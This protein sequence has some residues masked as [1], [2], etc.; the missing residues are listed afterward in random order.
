MAIPKTLQN[1]AGSWAGKSKLNLPWLDED[2]RISTSTSKLH[3][4]TDDNHAFA[5]LTYTWEHEGKK[6]EGT[7]LVAGHSK[8]PEIEVAWVDSWHQNTGI[9]HCTGTVGE[10]DHIKVRGSYKAGT[11]VWGWTI[12]LKPEGEHIRLVMENVTPAGEAEWAVDA[13]YTRS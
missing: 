1:W 6:Q 10:G 2:K 5:T 11:E 13:L 7:L 9:L 12:A 8:S 3:V 4:D